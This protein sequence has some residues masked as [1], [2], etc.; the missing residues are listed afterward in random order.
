MNQQ[1]I[2]RTAHPPLKIAKGRVKKM[3]FRSEPP[4]HPLQMKKIENFHKIQTVNNHSSSKMP[5]GT[6]S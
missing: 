6:L 3:T 1:S 2:S 5:I 4:T